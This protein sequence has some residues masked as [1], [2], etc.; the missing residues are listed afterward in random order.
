[1]TVNTARIR[2]STVTDLGPVN[3]VICKVIAKGAG[4]PNAHLFTTL[5]R[6]RGLFRS[7]LFYSAH[8]MPG[9]RISRKETEMAILRVAHRRDCAYEMD[10]H[11]RLGRRAGIDRDLLA[12]I[13]AG[14]DAPR[15]S[16]RYAAILTA[17]DELVDS[18]SVTD[19][20]WAELAT[21]FDERQLIELVLLVTQYDGLA[22]TLGTL[23]VERDFGDQPTLE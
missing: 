11:I 18:K 8:L 12:L 3:W 19:A 9:G 1:M 4:V 5:G 10:H 22:T 23:G 17:V 13:Q 7:W 21:R 15:L 16:S 6:T 14:P 2:S 20:T